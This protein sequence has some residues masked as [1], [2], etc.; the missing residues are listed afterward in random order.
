MFGM[1]AW[2]G[3]EKEEVGGRREDEVGEGDRQEPEQEEPWM[4]A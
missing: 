3:L 4:P 1:A 2:M